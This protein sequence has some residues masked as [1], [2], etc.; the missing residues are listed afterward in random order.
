M[1]L[2][3]KQYCSHKDYRFI[4]FMTLLSSCFISLLF[5][6]NVRRTIYLDF[7]PTWRAVQKSLGDLLLFTASSKWSHSLIV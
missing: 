4:S 7:L 1:L 5:S 3:L 2:G 6:S